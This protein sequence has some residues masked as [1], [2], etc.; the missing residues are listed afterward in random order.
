MDLLTSARD[1]TVLIHQSIEVKGVK[2]FGSPTSVKHPLLGVRHSGFQLP[3]DETYQ[4]WRDIPDDTNILITHGPPGGILDNPFLFA[5]GGR[6][7]YELTKRIDIVR[8]QFH[9][10]GHYHECYGVYQTNTTTFINAASLSLIPKAARH[11]PI[12]FD[13]PVN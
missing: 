6:G 12:V 9:V 4:I 7:D 8:P 13:F 2:F 3:R 1:A 5:L 10:F 11:A